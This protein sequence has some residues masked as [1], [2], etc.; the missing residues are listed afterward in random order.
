MTWL[1][2]GALVNSLAAAN[3][4]VPKPLVDLASRDSRF[5]KGLGSHGTAAR[6]RGRGNAGRGRSQVLPCTTHLPAKC[7]L[8]TLCTPSH[9]LTGI[10]W[11]STEGCSFAPRK[12][13]PGT[14][15]EH[16]CRWCRLAG[17]VWALGLL[18]RAVWRPQ[19]PPQQPA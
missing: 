1:T 10:V 3:Q 7:P 15:I 18:V 19:C 12:S 5:R 11:D 14:Q 2:A 9:S 8:N 4:E 16:D 6:G 13:V 17:Q